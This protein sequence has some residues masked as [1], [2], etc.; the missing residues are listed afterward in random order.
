MNNNDAAESTATSKADWL[1][2]IERCLARG[3]YNQAKSLTQ[4]ALSKFP[5]EV[6][7]LALEEK[8]IQQHSRVQRTPRNDVAH[9]QLGC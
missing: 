9:E 1:E 8:S 5:D 6:E 7:F 3:D 4:S 2:Q